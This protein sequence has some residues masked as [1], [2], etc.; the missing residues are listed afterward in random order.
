MWM[1]LIL[2]SAINL[3]VCFETFITSI[4]WE[5]LSL[6]LIQ[7]HVVSKKSDLL[8]RKVKQRFSFLWYLL[9]VIINNPPHPP[10][11]KEQIYSINNL[12]KFRVRQEQVTKSQTQQSRLK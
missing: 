8:T 1:W 2:W 12:G 7:T 11:K 10:Q 4:R 6:T 5:F 9:F 3:R